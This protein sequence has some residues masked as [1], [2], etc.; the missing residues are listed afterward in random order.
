[1]CASAPTPVRVIALGSAAPAHSAR[2]C[3]P[4]ACSHQGERH[5]PLHCRLCAHTGERGRDGRRVALTRGAPP[6]QPIRTPSMQQ[7]RPDV[8]SPPP[9]L[10]VCVTRAT[11]LASNSSELISSLTFAARKRRKNMSLTL[12]Q[13]RPVCGLGGPCRGWLAVAHT[14]APP[15]C[16]HTAH[17]AAACLNPPPLPPIQPNICI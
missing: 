9:A 16:A 5:Q 7:Q 3:A 1:M 8:T 10:C 14:A 15:L 2:V 4:H 17:R 11:Q 13:V 6:H 12:S